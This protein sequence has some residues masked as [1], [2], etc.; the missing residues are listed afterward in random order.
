M[1][2]CRLLPDHDGSG[3]SPLPKLFQEAPPTCLD[4][5]MRHE[6]QSFEARGTANC[7]SSY[8]K[9]SKLLL[10]AV[11]PPVSSPHGLTTS[12][13]TMSCSRTARGLPAP[14]AFPP[15]Q[16]YLRAFACAAL[17]PGHCMAGFQPFSLLSEAF[18][19]HT[20]WRAAPSCFIFY[21]PSH[22]LNSHVYLSV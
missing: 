3:R 8:S 2:E 21:S 16:S 1:N 19:D 4:E 6:P 7:P 9:P 10:V 14:P 20:I 12:S 17:C 11:E 22:Y 5:Y 13:P 18:S 15:V